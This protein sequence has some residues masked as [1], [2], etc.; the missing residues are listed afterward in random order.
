MVAKKTAFGAGTRDFPRPNVVCATLG[1]AFAAEGRDTVKELVFNIDDM[2][3]EALSFAV[4]RLFEAGAKDVSVAS[5]LMKKGRPGWTVT[6]LCGAEAADAV[7][8]AAFRHTSTIGMRER[9]CER[10]VA[11]RSVGMVGDGARVKTSLAGGVAKRKAEADDAARI[12]LARGI[13]FGEAKRMV[14]S[15]PG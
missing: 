9:V 1:E 8:E 10:R 14:E 15:W 13:S 5:V 7:A 4:D 6:A 3:G 12:A 11:R 2:T